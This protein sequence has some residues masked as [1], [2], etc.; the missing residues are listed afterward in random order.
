MHRLA[1]CVFAL[2]ACKSTP[3]PLAE[4]RKTCEQLAADKQLK[5]GLSIDACAQQLK[6]QADAAD[7]ARRAEELVDRAQGLVLQGRDKRDAAN[8]LE[9]RDVLTALAGLGRPAVAPTLSR[10]KASND[11]ELRIALAKVLVS[12]CS[13]DC[14]SARYD[15]IVPA[16]LE[17]TTYD[18]PSEVRKESEKGLVHCTG[19]QLGDDPAAWRSWWA[20]HEAQVA[21][22]ALK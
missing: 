5:A 12:T 9:L 14:A 13:S 3:D 6:A 4:Q 22:S 18:K 2:S 19:E 11:P 8:Q 16:L 1:I 21:A 15:C 7:P 20:A 17:G 10:L